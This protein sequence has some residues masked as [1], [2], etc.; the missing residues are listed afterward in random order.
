MVKYNMDPGTLQGS[1]AASQ[2]SQM[3]G[4]RVISRVSILL[5]ASQHKAAGEESDEAAESNCEGAP[6]GDEG[7]EAVSGD[8]HQRACK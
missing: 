3:Q 8:E 6:V 5:N 7:W 1:A 2:P 4:W